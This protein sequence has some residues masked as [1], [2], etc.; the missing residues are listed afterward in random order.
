MSREWRGWSTK[1]LNIRERRRNLYIQLRPS[2]QFSIRANV[3]Y[4]STPIQPSKF[5]FFRWIQLKFNND[6]RKR[7]GNVRTLNC[8]QH[9]EAILQTHRERRLCQEALAFSFQ[10]WCRKRRC[11]TWSGRQER[12]IEVPHMER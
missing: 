7:V 4:K 5:S 9:D 8:E 10:T 11:A 12:A 1:Y 3:M 2:I 6:K